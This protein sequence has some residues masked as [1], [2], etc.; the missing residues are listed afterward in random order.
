MVTES[1]QNKCFWCLTWWEKLGKRAVI[2]KDKM[3][4][5]CLFFKDRKC[6][7]FSPRT[8]C[9]F[10]GKRDKKIYHI[11]QR[12]ADSSSVS[13][14]LQNRLYACRQQLLLRKSVSAGASVLVL[15][16]VLSKGP[17]QFC[18][19]G[20]TSTS[21]QHVTTLNFTKN[22]YNKANTSKLGQKSVL[23]LQNSIFLHL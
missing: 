14:L 5:R 11:D 21:Q 8:W 12:S 7:H 16:D 22:K 9:V 23:L 2:L 20:F 17:F 10:P 6:Q 13:R 3:L 18:S 19:P 15:L 1:N 4:R